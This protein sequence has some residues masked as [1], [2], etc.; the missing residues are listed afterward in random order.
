MKLAYCKD[1]QEVIASGDLPEK[2]KKIVKGKWVEVAPVY[3]HVVDGKV[4]VAKLIDVPPAPTMLKE[5]PEAYLKRL[6]KAHK[7]ILK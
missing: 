3:S 7:G 1:C 2:V 6:G 4:H 5:S